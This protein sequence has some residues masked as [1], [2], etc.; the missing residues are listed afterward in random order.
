M[1]NKTRVAESQV[2][3]AREVLRVLEESVLLSAAAIYMDYL[4]DAAILEVQKR[5][6]RALKQTQDRFN[7]GKVA[8]DVA[9]SSSRMA[10]FG[11]ESPGNENNKCRN[12][13]GIPRLRWPAGLML[14]RSRALVTCLWCCATVSSIGA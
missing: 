9:Q 6:T 10:F 13:C 12:R 4:R 1:A 2:S 5:N 14:R 7:V 11:R 8:R 3:G